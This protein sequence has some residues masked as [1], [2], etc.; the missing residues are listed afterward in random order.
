[1]KLLVNTLLL[2]L[3]GISLTM[4][5]CGPSEDFKEL[6]RKTAELYSQG[7]Y[8]EAAEVAEKALEVA[9]KKFELI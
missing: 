8:A 6:N 7:R 9:E 4:A 2:A 3:A 1:M 5:G